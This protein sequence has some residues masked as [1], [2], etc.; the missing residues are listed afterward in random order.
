[1]SHK[2]GAHVKA[3]GVALELSL[4]VSLPHPTAFVPSHGWGSPF[5]RGMASSRTSDRY[6]RLSHKPEVGLTCR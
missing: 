1:M 3:L 2:K 5:K 4:P 6:S